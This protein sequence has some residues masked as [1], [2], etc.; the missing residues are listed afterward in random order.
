MSYLFPLGTTS[1][2]GQLQVGPNIDVDLNSIISIPQSVAT[3]A[4]LTFNSV[5]V[6]SALTLNGTPVVYKLIAG[7]NITLSAT[8]GVVT[9][10]AA[11]EGIL[12]TV[13]TATNYTAAADDEYI[14][15]TATPAL[16]TLPAGIVGK[17][18][19]IKNEASSGNTT[20]KGTG[21]EFIDGTATKVLSSYASVSVVFRNNKW[22]VI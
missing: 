21:A 13:G 8:S 9:I 6:T 17:T 20:I 1:E 22:N 15:V 19:I 3:T 12:K 7:N 10:S 14:G 11:T 18:Y 4:D 2:I 5:D 16:I